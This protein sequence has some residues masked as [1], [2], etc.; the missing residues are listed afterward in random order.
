MGGLHP[1]P[2]FPE[3]LDAAA[4]SCRPGADQS[5]GDAGG[6]WIPSLGG[7]RLSAGVRGGSRPCPSPPFPSLIPFISVKSRLPSSPPECLPHSS[8]PGS[9]NIQ[10]NQNSR[11]SPSTFPD[12]Q[13]L[14]FRA[15]THH[16]GTGKLRQ[17]WLLTPS[18]GTAFPSALFSCRFS[19]FLSPASLRHWFFFWV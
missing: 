18:P 9:H 12:R 11:M 4:V 5:V 6:G 3:V 14:Y 17:G 13:N 10:G 1:S 16:A 7:S 8:L 19:S 15:Q 2:P